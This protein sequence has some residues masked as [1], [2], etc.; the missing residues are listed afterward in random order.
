MSSQTPPQQS[1]DAS[2][3]SKF[4][5]TAHIA[6]TASAIVG[7]LILIVGV[8]TLIS[9]RADIN[10]RAEKE[11]VR[12]WQEVVV[13]SIIAKHGFG[14][15]TF[16]TIRSEYLD[17][18]QVFQEFNIPQKAIQDPALNR[19]L[20]E[21]LSRQVILLDFDQKYAINTLGPAEL[22]QK[23]QD[24]ILLS[25]RTD[26]CVYTADDIYP[27]INEKVETT[28]QMFTSVISFLIAGRIIDVHPFDWTL[29][30]VIRP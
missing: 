2:P 21:L 13:F 12:Q 24:A 16:K 20:L 1:P 30:S 29:C 19:M 22:A 9:A 3:R 25:V 28:P 4:Q 8:V 10:D 5:I 26:S 17:E 18:V 14:G 11:R 7:A 27:R 23:V 15:A 6:T